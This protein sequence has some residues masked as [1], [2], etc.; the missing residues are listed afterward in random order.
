MKGE[1]ASPVRRL[2]G[3]LQENDPAGYERLDNLRRENPAAFREEIRSRIQGD[4]LEK[5]KERRPAIYNAMQQLS[6]E[7]RAWLF[8]RLAGPGLPSHP[9]Y[10]HAAGRESTK[11]SPGLS[12]YARAY[13]QA[14]SDEERTAI[15]T[16]LADELGRRYDQQLEFRRAQLNQLRGKM[17]ELESTILE[18]ELER[19][20]FIA[21]KTEA[22]LKRQRD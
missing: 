21:E 2:M 4:A 5:I 7:D 22:W 3:H 6:V 19:A 12:S 9:G 16:R 11:A 15:R 13:H 14:G 1:P 10:K 8:E 17:N 20:T 18:G